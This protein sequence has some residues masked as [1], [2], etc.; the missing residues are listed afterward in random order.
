MIAALRRAVDGLLGRGESSITVPP[1]DGALQPNQLLEHAEIV[2]ELPDGEDIATDGK[3]IY[4]ADGAAIGRLDGNSLTEVR[5]FD[6]TI[7]AFCLLP[8]GGLAVALDGTEVRVFASIDSRRPL[9][10]RFIR[11]CAQRA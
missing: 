10:P 8:G 7:T 9:A 5:R 11:S 1:F 2:A 6:R 4:V 3:A